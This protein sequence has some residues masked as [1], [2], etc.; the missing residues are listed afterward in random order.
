MRRVLVDTTA[1][2]ALV[3]DGDRHHAK[4]RVALAAVLEAG[5]QLVLPDVVFS[6]SMTLLRARHGSQVAT[7]VGRELRDASSYHWQALGRA[8]EALT[9][10]IFQRYDDKAWSYVDCA[11]LALARRMGIQDIF[12]FDRHFD[13]MPGITRVGG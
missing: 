9:W 2:Y 12:A 3:V 13:Q 6:E 7:R 8:G 4:A 11:L 5:G 10:E 1:V